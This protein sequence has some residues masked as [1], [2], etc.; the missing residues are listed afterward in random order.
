MISPK[1]NCRD[2]DGGQDGDKEHSETLLTASQ[3]YSFAFFSRVSKMSLVGR[4][5]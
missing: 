4:R 1:T 3:L 2:E 5:R